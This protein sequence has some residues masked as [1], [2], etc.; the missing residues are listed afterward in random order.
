MASLLSAHPNVV[1]ANELD[2]LRLVKA[3]FS[4]EQIYTLILDK[5]R[6]F[7]QA[8]RVWTGYQYQI[9]HQWQGRHDRLQVIGDKRAGMTT[10]RLAKHPSLLERLRDKVRVR[11]RVIHVVRNPYDNISTISMRVG[12]PLE[13]AADRYFEVC[14]MVERMAAALDPPDELIRVRHEDLVARPEETLVAL[15]RSVGI[16]ASHE[17]LEACSALVHPEPHRSRHEVSWKPDLL[18]SVEA[19]VEKVGFLEGYVFAD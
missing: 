17:Y 5:D 8:G 11:L 15:C 14:R 4:R 6:A 16:D 3:G 10:F 2:V 18:R 7:D 9:P 12:M 19:R 13:L 1:I